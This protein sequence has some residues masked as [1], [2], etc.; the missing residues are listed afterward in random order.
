MIARHTNGLI[1]YNS[2]NCYLNIFT[3]NLSFA[4]AATNLLCESHLVQVN[5]FTGQTAILIDK[6]QLKLQLKSMVP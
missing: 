5:L 4:Q 2:I 3:L 1:F 6:I